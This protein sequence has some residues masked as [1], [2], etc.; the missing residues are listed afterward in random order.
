MLEGVGKK[1]NLHQGNKRAVRREDNGVVNG[2]LAVL[3]RLLRLR[4]RYVLLRRR[5]QAR[6][7]DESCRR[8]RR[9]TEEDGLVRR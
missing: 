4:L 3:L 8:L 9:S 7:D 6:H 1:N 2:Q 5:C